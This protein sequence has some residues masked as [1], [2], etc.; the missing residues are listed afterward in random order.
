MYFF[1]G[2]VL[3]LDILIHGSVRAKLKLDLKEEIINLRS[4]FIC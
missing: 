2:V 3:N 1:Y 4:S